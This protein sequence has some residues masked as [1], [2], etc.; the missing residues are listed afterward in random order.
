MRASSHPPAGGAHVFQTCAI[1]SR[2]PGHRRKDQIQHMSAEAPVHALEIN[3]PLISVSR[4]VSS[5]GRA[6]A[7]V[8]P[9]IAVMGLVPATCNRAVETM[10]R[11]CP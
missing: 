1:R 3:H 7:L 10:G 4:F 8:C 2:T 6:S 9:C 11:G 5:V